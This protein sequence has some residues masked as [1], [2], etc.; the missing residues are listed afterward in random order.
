VRY[1]SVGVGVDTDKWRVAILDERQ[2]LNRHRAILSTLHDTLLSLVLI[3]VGW[4]VGIL[5]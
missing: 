2:R 1:T 5:Q 3:D 4:W